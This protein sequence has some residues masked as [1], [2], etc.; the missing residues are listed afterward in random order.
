[1]CEL[2]MSEKRTGVSITGSDHLLVSP[3]VFSIL[4]S[5]PTASITPLKQPSINAIGSDNL[6]S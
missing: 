1:M 6:K 4:T 2:H 5:L 3:M